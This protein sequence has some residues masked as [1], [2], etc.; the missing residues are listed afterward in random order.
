MNLQQILATWKDY[1]SVKTWKKGLKVNSHNNKLS[2][3]TEEAINICMPLF[4]EFKQK[5]PDEIIEEALNGKYVVRETLSDFCTWLQDEK[6]KTFNHAVHITH[7]VVRGIYSH[8]DINTQKIKIP[9]RDPSLVQTTDDNLPLYDIVEIEEEDGKKHK[10]KK[11]RR[12]LIRKFFDLMPFRDKIQMMCIKDI[13]AD[14]GDIQKWTL[15]L[16][17][18]QE[19]QERIFIRLKR[20]KTGQYVCYFLSKE[21]TQLI[22]RYEKQYRE[23]ADDSELIFVQSMIE[24]KAAFCRE[25]GRQFIKGSDEINLTG[26]TTKNL[27]DACRV[28]AERLEKLLENEGSPIKI[29]R[30]NQQSPLRPKRFRK[31][32]SDACDDA[33]LPVDI[34]R[35]F[36][37]KKDPANQS[38][39]P[40]SRQDLELY[41]E[42]IEP[43]ITIYSDPDPIPTEEL[44]KLKARLKA[45]ELEKEDLRKKQDQTQLDNQK[46]FAR[47]EKMIDD[48][49]K[50]SK[51][52][53]NY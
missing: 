7:H 48:K 45:S 16:I 26:L 25:H 30:R 19:S 2:P 41:Y 1:A 51:K 52:D 43:I 9:T 14:S 22:R 4:L 12:E 18:N 23:L 34:K 39:E 53:P 6:G 36:M 17:R 35:L 29:L 5:T 44:Q 31:V 13:G 10:V 24:F 32:F 40:K 20:R 15:G 38:Y 11:I 46:Q 3:K 33:G 50:S 49:W 42:R 8:N 47:L 21:T 28:A 37:G 27:S